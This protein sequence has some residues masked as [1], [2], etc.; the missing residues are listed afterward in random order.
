[1]E[2]LRGV[3][4]VLIF[5][6]GICL[7]IKLCMSPFQL[8]LLVV[9]V[10]CFLLA[11]FIWPSKKNNQREDNIYLDVLEIAIELPFEIF[12][13]LFRILVRVFH[14]ADFPDINP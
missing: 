1:M 2:M 12:I 5:I 14:K 11:Y 13:W 9:V 7:L 8:M 4:A 3:A 10:F 6:L